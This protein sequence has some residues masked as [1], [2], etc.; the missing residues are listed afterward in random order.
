MKEKPQG[1]S[2]SA[3]G[4]SVQRSAK[5]LVN[6]VIADA[7]RLYLPPRR[8]KEKIAQG[9]GAQRLPPW[10]TATP[11]STPLFVVCLADLA[12]RQGRP[13]REGI[14]IIAP[15]PRAAL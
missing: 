4:G 12:G 7:R 8:G 9:K 11:A 6:L 5:F 1:K 2:P 10:V 15:L 3:I 13:R 14:F